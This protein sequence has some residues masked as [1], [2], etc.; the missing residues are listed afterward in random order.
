MRLGEA[1]H[2]GPSSPG[3]RD[4]SFTLGAINPTGLN[5]KHGV[6]S[7]LDCPAVYMVSEAHLTQAG[8]ESFRLG[9]R[10]SGGYRYVSGQPVAFRARSE[11][12]GV[13][14][15]VGFLSSFPCKPAPHS[16]PAEVY[17]TSRVQVA[18]FFAE[19]LWILGGVAY[20]YVAD[21]GLVSSVVI[22]IW[23]LIALTFWLLGTTMAL[24]RFR[25]SFNALLGVLPR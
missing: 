13:Y 3:F 21:Q 17:A 2:P 14:S 12:S 15:G 22:S 25:I 4:F 19:P 20:G 11:M 7:Q 9:L 6:V 5:G 18:H 16:W 1:S 10:L 8:L 24:L 23:R